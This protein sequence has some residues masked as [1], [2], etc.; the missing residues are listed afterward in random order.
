MSVGSKR[1][2]REKKKKEKEKRSVRDWQ[3]CLVNTY[4]LEID[5][6][7]I[8]EIKLWLHLLIASYLI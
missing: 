4:Y 5:N 2:E 3:G 8:C 1:K 7:I 6:E